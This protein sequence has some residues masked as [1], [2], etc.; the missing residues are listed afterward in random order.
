M[1]ER[2]I[3]LLE[4][5]ISS[6]EGISDRVKKLEVDSHPQAKITDEELRSKM[7]ELYVK[8]RDSNQVGSYN[9]DQFGLT[10]LSLDNPHIK[11]IRV[12]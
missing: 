4:G 2:L 3:N 8:M 5:I 7:L 11:N 9:W 1:N 10:P 6:I 12:C